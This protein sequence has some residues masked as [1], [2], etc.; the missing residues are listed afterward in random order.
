MA[1][2]EEYLRLI[3]NE[4]I[5]SCIDGYWIDN[6]IRDSKQHPDAPFSDIGPVLERLLEAGTSREDLCHI[7]RWAS[8][9][10]AY[11]ALY[12]LDDPGIDD[13]TEVQDDL[14]MLHEELLAA[15]PSGQEG[16]PEPWP[17]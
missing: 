9:E 16:R 8:Y 1:Q 4:V 14:S 7:A 5:N 17:R 12:F 11:G 13:L 10:A 3:W 15:D 2:R 6:C